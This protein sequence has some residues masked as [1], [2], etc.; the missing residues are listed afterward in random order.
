MRGKK[1]STDLINECIR[2]R[3]VEKLSYGEIYK[4][5]GVP[6]GTL[7]PILKNYK[8][9][10]GDQKRFSN[11][12]GWKSPLEKRTKFFT[13]ESKYSIITK[14]IE[15]TRH[16]KAKIA[17]SAILFR[18]CLLKYIVYGSP[19]DGDKADWLIETHDTPGNTKRIQVRWVKT[20]AEG[21]PLISL[22]CMVHGK[23][24]RFQRG[25]FDFIIGYCLFND[26]AYVYS[27]DETEKLKTRVSVCESA[28][29]AWNKLL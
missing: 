17:E 25:D 3:S 12:S 19:F 15:L 24:R 9:S 23:Q 29:E 4:K 26:T 10:R 13:F 27:F 14:N 2:L 18:L 20:E 16:D 6:R 21:L 5:T 22:V 11:R 8:L 7:S 1:I 28:A